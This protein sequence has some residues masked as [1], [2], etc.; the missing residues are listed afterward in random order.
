MKNI[1]S[2]VTKSDERFFPGVVALINSLSHVEYKINLHVIDFGLTVNQIEWLKNKGCSVQKVTPKFFPDPSTISGTHYNASIYALL[3]IDNIEGDVIVHL[4]ADV[5]VVGGISNFINNLAEFD[6][7]APTDYPPLPFVDQIG[8]DNA[9]ALKKHFG[10]II[11]DND[12]LVMN[13]INAGIWAVTVD[14]FHILRK[15]MIEIYNCFEHQ[16]IV[17][18]MRDQSLLNIALRIANFSICKLDIVY[19]F[20]A[21][22]RRSPNL[23]ATF[24][25]HSV[26]PPKILYNEREICFIHFI[27]T[28]PWDATFIGDE[29]LKYIWEYYFQNSVENLE[30]DRETK[31]LN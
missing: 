15:I 10:D 12:S 11:F 2:V 9:I 7:V 1:V 14:K 28:K 19:N 24:V 31:T 4:D 26:F 8:S 23:A 6:F 17:L 20:R 25:D 22:F 21:H 18:P 3:Y 13:S 29:R 5:I 30:K 16:G 27:G